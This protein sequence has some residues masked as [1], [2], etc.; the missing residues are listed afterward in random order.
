MNLLHKRLVIFILAISVIFAASFA[1][2][3]DIIIIGSSRLKPV[4]D[5]ISIIKE[6]LKLDADIYSPS[7]I[8]GRLLSVVRSERA[9]AVVVL[10]AEGLDDALSLPESVPVIYGLMI[11]PVASKRQN[12]TGIFMA[13]PVNEYNTL[14]TRYIPSI[15]KI[16]IVHEPESSFSQ[17]TTSNVKLTLYK[18]SNPYEFVKGIKTL[19]SNV[20][21]LLLLPE[22]NLLSV[23]ALEELFLYSFAEKVP[24]IGVSEKHVKMGALLALVFDDASMARQL[25]R[26]VEKVVSQGQAV[27]IPEAGPEKFNLYVNT[28]TARRFNISTPSDFLSR[29]RKV[30][31]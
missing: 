13:T 7:E 3:S 16:G 2:S 20:D 15:R 8:N 5:V 17:A 29:A 21:A 24:V 28:E 23:A 1:E 30:Y 19:D 25:G 6:T 10:G 26:L 22:R 27:G 12:I 4:S 31:P 14:L 9:K 18:A 11:K